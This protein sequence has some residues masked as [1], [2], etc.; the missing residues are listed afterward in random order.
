MPVLVAEAS[1][2]SYYYN[3]RAVTGDP[4]TY[5]GIHDEAACIEAGAYIPRVGQSYPWTNPISAYIQAR[6]H[7]HL[8]MVLHG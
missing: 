6:I 5:A 1:Y 2:D 7:R 8:F 4:S 3:Y